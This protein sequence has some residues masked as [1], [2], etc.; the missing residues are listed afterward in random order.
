MPQFR[1]F[2]PRRTPAVTVDHAPDENQP[3]AASSA[4]P[5]ED[6]PQRLSLNIRRSREEPTNEYKMSGMF[7]FLSI[8]KYQLSA[9]L[10]VHLIR[11]YN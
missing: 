8:Y 2:F 11:P 5:A 10:L 6:T 4:N 9:A 3:P 7:F 1:N